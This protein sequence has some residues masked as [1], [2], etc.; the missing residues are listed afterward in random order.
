[1]A[2]PICAGCATREEIGI[3]PD[4]NAREFSG[5]AF[6][7]SL[8]EHVV[9]TEEEGP[10]FSVYRFSDATAERL[11]VSCYSGHH[12]DFPE[13]IAGNELRHVLIHGKPARMFEM[14]AAGT[15]NALQVLVDMGGDDGYLHYWY[16]GLTADEAQI[17]DAI[18]F[19]TKPK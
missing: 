14:K 10:D 11:L 2:V 19:S 8:P 17:A 16:G 9:A 4:E 3:V 1:M 6:T 7:L 15:G 18:V 5:W 12:P 13:S